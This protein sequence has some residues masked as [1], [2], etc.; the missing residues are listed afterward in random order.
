VRL[1][2]RGRPGCRGAPRAGGPARRGRPRLFRGAEPRAPAAA[3]PVAAPAEPAAA[4][5]PALFYAKR[6]ADPG[7]VPA[8]VAAGVEFGAMQARGRHALGRDYRRALCAG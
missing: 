4:P 1:L 6:I 5:P 7:L 8:L 2:S 3:G